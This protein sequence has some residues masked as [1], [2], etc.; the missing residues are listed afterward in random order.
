MT[1]SHSWMRVS[2]GKKMV[3]IEF[4]RNLIVH[5]PVSSFGSKDWGMHVFGDEGGGG[6]GGGG[7]GGGLGGGE[8][9]GGWLGGLCR[10]WI[11]ASLWKV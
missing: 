9:G 3:W 7:D 10:M 1:K 4:S 8:M 2:S 5:D 11:C 6:E